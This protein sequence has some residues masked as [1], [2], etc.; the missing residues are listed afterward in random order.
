MSRIGWTEADPAC[1]D[2]D[3]ARLSGH[4][5]QSTVWGDARS[6]VDGIKQFRW[7]GR[8]TDDS[9][10]AMARIEV[11]KVPGLGRVAWIPRGPAVANNCDHS[12]IIAD[13]NKELRSRGFLLAAIQPWYALPTNDGALQTIWID[14]TVGEEQLFR[15]LEKQWRYGVGRAEREGVV[16]ETSTDS[17]EIE[18]FFRLCSQ[19]SDTKGFKL[20]GSLALIQQLLH[21]KPNSDVETKLFVARYQDRLGAGAVVMRCGRNTHYLWGG[22]DRELSGY[23]T[24]EA[25]QWA[26]IQWAARQGCKVYDLEGIDPINNP[27]TYKFKKKMGGMILNIPG[28][29]TTAL[30]LRGSVLKA[31]LDR[32][33]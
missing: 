26:V 32:R 4:P 21:T 10:V 6:I 8:A 5:L 15:N 1:W 30:R 31:I 18:A 11:R 29:R 20:P 7:T 17:D 9:L 27:G 16:V 28:I 19:I 24:G 13:L 23:R 33:Q 25:V 22:V 3:L 2:R 14:L 12:T